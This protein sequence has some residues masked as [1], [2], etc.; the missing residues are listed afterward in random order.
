M[1]TIFF[2][3]FLSV[4]GKNFNLKRTYDYFYMKCPSD[5]LPFLSIIIP[6][7][8]E[9]KVI[10]NTVKNIQESSY[11][12]FE[13]IIID[14]NSND[15]TPDIIEKLTKM[16]TNIIFLRK[17]GE[18]GKPQSL[19]E[20]LNYISGSIVLFLDADSI[21]P[22]NYIEYHLKRFFNNE[23]NLIFTDFEPYNYKTKF[24]YEYQ[25]IYFEFVKNLLYSNMFAKMIFMGNGLFIRKELL[26]KI[27]P[28]N[29]KTLVD[30]FNMALKLYELKAKEHFMLYPK[31][32]IQYV[33]S[34]KD[35]FNQHTR[36]YVGGYRE[37][38]HYIKEGN[39]KIIFTFLILLLVIFSPI[40]LFILDMIYKTN[41]LLQF[42]LPLFL[43]FWCFA[44]TSK[45]LKKNVSFR[46]FLLIV[47]VEIPIGLI[48][49]V[50][51]AVYSLILSIFKEPNWYKVKRD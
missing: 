3:L 8:N 33:T 28:L 40:I 9:E 27:L 2:S 14:D 44:F 22:D 50:I 25:D 26:E 48:I 42:L 43:F 21:I 31:V 41:L 47:L 35:L 29:P 16:Y 7:Y 11:K 39:L 23:I 37:I 45:I 19:N 13:I 36:W 32:K 38:Y 18:K 12:N 49:E 24:I 6:T 30:D 51:I 1:F 20:A 15:S 4:L 5:Y 34:L 46:D 10:F 17:I